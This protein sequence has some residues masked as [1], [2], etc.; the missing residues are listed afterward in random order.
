MGIVF[1]CLS[2]GARFEVDPRMAGK[3]GRCKKCGQPM[4]IPRPEHVA[5]MAAMPALAAAPAGAATGTPAPAGAGRGGVGQSLGGWLRAAASDVGLAP[6]TVDRMPIGMRRGS[7]PSPLDDAEDSKP[8]LLAE[9]VPAASRGRSSGRPNVVAQVWR[10]QLGNVQTV[11]R[12]INQFAYLISV[13]FLM[14]LLLGIAV[15]SR[16][17]ALAAATVV[18]LLNIGRIASGVVNLAVVPLRDG[19]NLKK[20]KKPFRR[21]AEPVL[22][23]GLVVVAFA[24]IPWLRTGAAAEGTVTERLRSSAK[25]IRNETKGHVDKTVG[26]VQGLDVGKRVRRTVEESQEQP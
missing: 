26:D 16:P 12:K 22:T 1:F 19:L 9:P 11:F 18:V 5:S 2:C 17:L 3:K 14:A 23:I 21:V 6:L 24:Y 4:E 13:P 20:M 8:Y 15:R 10:G 7:A 25:A